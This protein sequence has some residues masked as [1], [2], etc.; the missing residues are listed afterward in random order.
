MW[1]GGLV[2]QDSGLDIFSRA[3]HSGLQRRFW[4]IFERLS[5]PDYL[6][7]TSTLRSLLC[8]RG[9][10]YRGTLPIRKRPPPADPPRT[11][12][13]GPRQG[14]MGERVRFS[15]VPQYLGVYRLSS[16]GLLQHFSAVRLVVHRCPYPEALEGCLAGKNTPSPS[17]TVGP[18]TQFYCRVLGRVVHHER[19]NPVNLTP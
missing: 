19:E 8:P 4:D 17:T 13:I 14:P 6:C 5:D 16:F 9:M 15:E 3:P 11:L 12:G 18:R 10:A 7:I 1:P 2:N